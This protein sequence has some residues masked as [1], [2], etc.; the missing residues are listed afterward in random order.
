MNIEEQVELLMLGTEY[1]D[2]EL[3]KSMTIELRER[4]QSAQKQSRPLQVYC[5]YD[6][7]STDL[8]LGHTITMRKLRQFQDLGHKAVLIIGDYTALIGDPTG[9]NKTRPMLSNADIEKNA[10]TYFE[11]AGK[12]L[13]TSPDKLEIRR[14]GEWLAGIMKKVKNPRAGVLPDFG[15]FCVRRTKPATQDIAGW[16]A[17]QCLEEYDRYKGIA[18]LMPFAKGVHA[19]THVF[20]ANGNDTETDFTRMFKIIKDSGFKGWVSLEYEGG[21]MKMYS[22]DDK[23]LDDDKGVIATKKL[24][25]KAAMAV[26]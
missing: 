11:Q 6:P 4:L 22:K 25:E 19:K 1:G 3:K 24:V 12:I 20:D 8:H 2:E 23:Y 26:A 9:Q 18:E 13:D 15:N 10:K 7:T 17:T 16:M 14:N 5:G 21:L